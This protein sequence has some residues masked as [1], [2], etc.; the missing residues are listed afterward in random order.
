L[1]EEPD[2]INTWRRARRQE[3]YSRT[4]ENDVT[5]A[6]ALQMLEFGET[7]LAW[8]TLHR[9]VPTLEDETLE[10]QGYTTYIAALISNQERDVETE[11][12]HRNDADILWRGAKYVGE[13]VDDDLIMGNRA[14]LQDPRLNFGLRQQQL[15]YA[16]LRTEHL[17]TPAAIEFAEK[18]APTILPEGLADGARTGVV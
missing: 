7:A 6:W 17:M 8:R 12:I 13:E 18:I 16:A 15:G 2:A 9:C 10:R 14:E 5:R 11:L 4:A 1:D 3:Q